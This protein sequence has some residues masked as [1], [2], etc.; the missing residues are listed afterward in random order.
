[1]NQETLRQVQMTQLEI[2]KEIKRV[3][4]ENH[5]RFFLDSGSTIGAA[6]HK[7]FIPWDDDMDIGML[8]SEYEKFIKIAPYALDKKY[9]LQTWDTDP[10]YPYFFAKIRKIGTMFK[11]TSTADSL[12]HNEIWVD[13]FPYDSFPDNKRDQLEQKKKVTMYEYAITVKKGV[14]RWLNHDKLVE[15]CLV[16]IKYLPARIFG[17]FHS[18]ESM[19]KNMEEWLTKYNLENTEYLYTAVGIIPYGKWKIHRSCFMDYAYLDFE[20]DKFPVPGDYETYLTEGY[21]DWRKLPPVEK[22]G[23]QHKILEIK[24]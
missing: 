15:Q 3:C 17:W 16:W 24:L 13:I 9:F 1:M 2:G 11:E 12:V 22:R 14:K 19:Q 23:N 10:Q 4:E 8:R 18:V 7:G 21:G 5:I 20:D 6:R